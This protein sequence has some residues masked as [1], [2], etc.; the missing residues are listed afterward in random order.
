[1]ESKTFPESQVFLLGKRSLDSC[2]F[3][4]LS[5]EILTIIN[6]TFGKIAKVDMD[7]QYETLLSISYKTK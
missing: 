1:M 5:E 7:I 4:K 3:N 6:C 2:V